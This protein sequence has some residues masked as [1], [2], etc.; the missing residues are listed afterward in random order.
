[1]AVDRSTGPKRGWIYIVWAE[2]DVSRPDST[3]DIMLIRSTDGGVSWSASR[4]VNQD[5]SG[6]DQWSPWIAVDPANGSLFIVYY[7]SRNFSQNDS[8]QVYISFSINGGDTFQDTLVSDAAF[9]PAS[10][11]GAG[12]G[13]MGDYIGIAAL[14]NIV[15]PAWND[16]RTGIHQ[17]YTAKLDFNGGGGPILC[18]PV[19]WLDVNQDNMLSLVDVAILLNCVFLN[20]M[21][22]CE[23]AWTT[24]DVVML[25]NGLFS[26]DTRPPAC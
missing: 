21:V 17:A 11:A 14:N 26:P 5:N 10:I 12:D 13:Y 8:A 16:N 15:W 1:M 23:S 24:A 7:D 25:L 3:P 22:S 4:K 9:L 19:A 18:L 20:S 6:K 2:K